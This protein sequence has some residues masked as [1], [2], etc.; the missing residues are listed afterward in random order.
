MLGT[1]NITVANKEEINTILDSRLYTSSNSI[2]IPSD[3]DLNDYITPGQYINNYPSNTITNLP[4]I[5][6][7]SVFTLQVISFGVIDGVTQLLQTVTDKSG[8]TANRSISVD[9]ENNIT[10]SEWI[11]GGGGSSMS[12]EDILRIKYDQWISDIQSYGV[13]SRIWKDNS[14]VK[15]LKE[16]GEVYKDNITNVLVSTSDL[17][18]GDEITIHHNIYG[19]IPLIVIG[20]NHDAGNSV[21]LLSKEI[22]RLLAFDAKEANNSDTDRQKYGNNRY[23]Y[24][25]LLQWMNSDKAAGE[26]YTARHSAD[27]APDR[28]NVWNSYNPYS[29]ADGFLRGFDKSLVDSMI[30]VDKTT[31]LNTV[32]D[33]GGSEVVSSKVFLLSTTEVGL[34]NE[35]SI[36]EGKIYEYF[37]NNNVDA[38]RLAYPSEYCLNNTEYTTGNLAS[39]KP[40]YW[41]LRTPSSGSY[42]N[43]RFVNTTGA[44]SS[45]RAFNGYYG[46][47]V[48][49]TLP[50]NCIL[51]TISVEKEPDRTTYNNGESFDSTGMEVKAIYENGISGIV[52]NSLL[53]YTPSIL[54][55]D[56][57]SVKIEYSE[58]NITK[59]ANI[60][61]IVKDLAVNVLNV[62]IGDEIVIPHSLYGDIPFIVIGRDHD[63]DNSVTVLSKEIIRLLPFDAK[64]ASNSDTNRK[65]YGNNRYLYSNLLQWM[66]SDKAA[67]SWYTAQHSADTAPS[68]TSVVTYNPYSN[69]DGFLKGF[70]SDVVDQMITVDKTTALN[71]ITD[72]GG[73]E[74]VSSKVFLLSST[75]VGLADE[76]SIAEGK[77]YEY[78]SNNNVNSQ[79]LA[80]PSEY[81]LNNAGGYTNTSFVSGKPWYWWLRTPDSGDSC[82][83]RNVDASGALKVTS[84]YYGHRGLRVALSL[85]TT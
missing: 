64:E 11:I 83:V 42:T 41:W 52:N 45:D 77:I 73:S 27:A 44:H 66:N 13:H 55:P 34:A 6:D 69:V 20:R 30:T 72:S 39:G 67:G 47:R 12:S 60:A 3:A 82:D 50:T 75:E 48:A 74:V 2:S 33:G 84:A 80:Y 65:S 5:E 24:S 23:L 56:N 49:F 18:V 21:T 53:T 31:A 43:V 37:S 59:Y 58:N 70:S 25:N 62:S 61:V 26:W 78:F 1:V 51:S 68:N 8:I 15:L 4:S 57:T 14:K 22:I 40:W 29:N 36:A 35:N 32:T 9:S 71:T 10:F 16:D 85:K 54:T 38:Q 19:N 7:I 81:C 76:N 46:L 63:A 79:R 28:A 17:N